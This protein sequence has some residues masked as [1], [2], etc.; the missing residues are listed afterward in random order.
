MRLRH[1]G[2]Q[3][4]LGV[5]LAKLDIDFIFNAIADSMPDIANVGPIR[6]APAPAAARSGRPDTKNMKKT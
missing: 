3:N 5:S 1:L 4:C 6:S 2:S